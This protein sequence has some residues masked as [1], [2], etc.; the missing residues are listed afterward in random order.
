M[1]PLTAGLANGTQRDNWSSKG[2]INPNTGSRNSGT[3]KMRFLFFCLIFSLAT[4]ANA[5]QELSDGEIRQLIIHQSIA[6][7][8]GVCACPYSVARNG[9]RCGGRSAYSKQ[10]GYSPLCYPQDV[11]EDMVKKYKQAL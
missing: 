7:Y 9:S 1:S 10:G 11:T 3:P 4:T 8:V 6:Q 2:N 5:K